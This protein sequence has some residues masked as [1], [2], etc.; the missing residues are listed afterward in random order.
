MLQDLGPP[1]RVSFWPSPHPTRCHLIGRPAKPAAT[2]STPIRSV[3]FII[4]PLNVCL[5]ASSAFLPTV[6]LHHIKALGGPSFFSS[7]MLRI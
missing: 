2:G 4:P 7:T 6:N 3:C 1:T 5:P